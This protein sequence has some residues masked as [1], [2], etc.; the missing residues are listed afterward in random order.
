M[1]RYTIPHLTSVRWPG[2]N[3]TKIEVVSPNDGKRLGE[4]EQISVADVEWLAGLTLVGQDKMNSTPPLERAQWL[5]GIAQ[6]IRSQRDDLAMLIA[7][8]GGK[9]LRDAL[10]EADRAA[11]TFD[12]CAE[13]TLSLGSETLPLAQTA[14]GNGK[15]VFTMREPIGPVLALSAFNHPLNLLAHQVGTALAAGCSV[16]FKPSRGT[17]FCG[18]WLANALLHVGV[19]AEAPLCVTLMLNKSSNSLRARNFNSSP[20]LVRPKWDGTYAKKLLQEL[21]L[22]SSMAAK[23]RRLFGTMRTWKKP[24]HL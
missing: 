2:E 24:W 13:E 10:V 4:V 15:L 1:Q 16:V 14:A 19:P 5:K 7:T 6:L 12:L 22:L 8:E 21:A 9:P 11:N 20:S 18:E 23:R 3:R 17:P